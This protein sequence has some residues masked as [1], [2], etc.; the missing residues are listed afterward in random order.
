MPRATAAPVTT[1]GATTTRQ[2]PRITRRDSTPL[3]T[4]CSRRGP[5]STPWF[6]A[7]ETSGGAWGWYVYERDGFREP[8]EFGY[9]PEGYRMQIVAAAKPGYAPTLTI[10]RPRRLCREAAFEATA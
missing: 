5:T 3:A 8:N 9:A 2:T 7:L 6:A 1:A 10:L 4:S